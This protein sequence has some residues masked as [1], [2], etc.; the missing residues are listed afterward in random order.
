MT[1][2]PQ[3]RVVGQHLTSP[4]GRDLPRRGSDRQAAHGAG[5][6][7]VDQG[8]GMHGARE[9]PDGTRYGAFSGDGGG[10]DLDLQLAAALLLERTR[11]S[12]IDCAGFFG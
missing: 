12:E 6:L 3:A 8:R 11:S 5:N 10:R 7:G 4:G 1:H 2:D 9:A